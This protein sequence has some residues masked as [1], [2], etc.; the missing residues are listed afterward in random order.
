MIESGI[1]PQ[2]RVGIWRVFYPWIDPDLLLLQGYVEPT[3]TRPSIIEFHFRRVVRRLVSSLGRLYQSVREWDRFLEEGGLTSARPYLAF[4]IPEEAG[5]AADSVF[6]Y[7]NLFIDDLARIIPFVLTEEVNPK[8]SDGFSAIKNI[9]IK[10]NLAAS[11]TLIKLF[12]ELNREASWW[13][14]GFRRGVGMRQRLTHYT[15]LVI[16]EGS[17]KPGD[18][19]MSADVS[20][21]TIGGPVRV[22]DFEEALKML[23]SDLCEWLDLLDNELLNCLSKQLK[24]KGVSWNPFDEPS[25]VVV[26]P[27]PDEAMLDASHYLYLP[28]CAQP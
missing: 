28:M 27:E 4:D 3:I 24:K 20:L 16:F 11:Q 14:R 22:A 15:D 2:F 21:A 25:P 13:S 5:I 19:K 26:L 18:A 23:L 1:R 12:A 8:E 6:H 7:L 9:L 17:T 10:G